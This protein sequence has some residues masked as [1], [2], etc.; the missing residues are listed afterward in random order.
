MAASLGRGRRCPSSCRAAFLS[1]FVLSARGTR[2][3]TGTTRET[4]S[5]LAR[6]GAWKCV[7]FAKCILHMYRDRLKSM[8]QVWWILS[9]LL[10]ATPSSTF[11]QHSRNLLRPSLYPFSFRR[12]LCRNELNYP[13]YL[14][15]LKF[16]SL[17]CVTIA[18]CD[19]SHTAPKYSFSVK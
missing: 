1:Y 19:C 3:I 2:F 4:D 5:A 6:P 15:L 9:L 16:I 17:G 7:A 13:E 18:S 12:M 14:V 11:L 10:L 8:L